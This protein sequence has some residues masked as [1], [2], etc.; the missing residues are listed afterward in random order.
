MSGINQSFPPHTTATN[1][2]F[3]RSICAGAFVRCWQV[4]QATKNVDG[5]LKIQRSLPV[6]RATV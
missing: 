6:L 2:E 5:S 4:L 1:P 3:C